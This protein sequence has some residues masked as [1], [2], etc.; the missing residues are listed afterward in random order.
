MEKQIDKKI[1]AVSGGVDSMF[2]LNM[3]KNENIVVVHVNYNIRDDVAIDFEIVSSF[4]KQN[5]LKL[6]TYSINEKYEGNFQEWA[7]EKRYKFFKKIYDKYDCNELIIAHHKDDFFETAIM[8]WNSKRN[9]YLFGMNK[10]NE[11]FGMNINRPLIFKYWKSEIYALA[12]E[13]N[14]PFNEDWTNFTNQYE[15]NRIRNSFAETSKTIK[16]IIF[17]SFQSINVEK[18]IKKIEI[19]KKYIQWSESSFNIDFLENNEDYFD[20]LIFKMLIENVDQINISS[21]LLKSLKIFLTTKNG[22]KDFLLS[23]QRKLVKFNNNVI[24]K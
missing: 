21:N 1:I 11:I 6:E 15:R 17:K 4:C 7:R 5:N 3:L 20:D 13:L 9:P 14:I 16:E 2:L 19:I 23:N 12:H 8:Q 18:S 24:I 22:N 10:R